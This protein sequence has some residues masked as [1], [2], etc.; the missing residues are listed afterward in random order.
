MRILLYGS[1][2]TAFNLLETIKI[3]SEIEVLA[4]LD[5]NYEK[6]DTFC[7]GCKVDAANNILQYKFDYILIASIYI[8]EILSI[9]EKNFKVDRNKIIPNAADWV[10]QTLI[11]QEY[12]KHYNLQ[13]KKK[14]DGDDEKVVI[15]T[16]LFGEYDTLKT[17]KYVDEKVDYICFTNNNNLS[18]NI[19]RIIYFQTSGSLD[20]CRYAKQFKVLPHMYLQ[21][22]DISIWIDAS[23]EI[24]NS[25]MEMLKNEL[26]NTNYLFFPHNT[27][28]CSYDEADI[29]VAWEL[30]NAE[31]INEQMKRYKKEGFPEK[32]GLIAAGAIVRRHMKNEVISLMEQWWYEIETGSKRDQ[33]SLMYCLWKN[34]AKYDLVNMNIFKNRYFEVFSHLNLRI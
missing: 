34:M 25:M 8:E 15:Y 9:L 11:N 20:L 17:P 6:K 16:A 24:N 18:S 19:W 1:G 13:K 22:Y 12:R 21:E 31:M 10:E 5:S 23:I 3:I 28:I 26:G 32:Y 30:D 27:R 7:N 29:C 33:I 14:Y 2:K 4:C